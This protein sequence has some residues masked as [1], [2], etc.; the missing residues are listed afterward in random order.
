[1]NEFAKWHNEVLGSKVVDALRKNGFEA[2]FC[3]TAAGR[4]KNSCAHPG[5]GFS[6]LRRVPY[7]KALGIQEK[8]AA[9]GTRFLTTTPPGF[10]TKSGRR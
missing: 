5:R 4:R 1:M 7:P 9:R 6:G 3:A 2:E 8:L 10:R